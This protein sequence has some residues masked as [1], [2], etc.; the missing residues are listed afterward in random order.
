VKSFG[1]LLVILIGLA[2]ASSAQAEQKG[3]PK[4]ASERIVLRTRLGDIVLALFPEAAPKTV[5]QMLKLTRLGVFSGVNIARVEPGFIVQLADARDRDAPMT[6]EQAAAITKIPAEFKLPHLRGSLTLAHGDDPNDGE[7]SFSM[8]FVDAPHLDGKYTVFG[9]VQKGMDVLETIARLGTDRE[10]HRPITQIRVDQA[11]VVDEKELPTLGLRGAQLLAPADAISAAGA[12]EVAAPAANENTRVFVC[13]GIM[14][15]L[16]LGTFLFAG[17]LS[18]KIIGS[19]GLLTVFVG[20]FLVF[21]ILAPIAPTVRWL[22]VA[23]FAGTIG[24]LKL[25]NRFETPR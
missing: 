1:H 17:K 25:A 24:I 14:A 12:S 23:M 22:G 11:V 15:M 10:T 19:L 3:L 18:A 6:S 7:T 13:V 16:G 20:F 2:L 4:V 5:A 8:L 21:T 9:Q